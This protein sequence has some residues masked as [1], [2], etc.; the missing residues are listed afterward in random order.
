MYS[1]DHDYNMVA[2]VLDMHRQLAGLLVVKRGVIDAKDLEIDRLVCQ[3]Y[4]L[5]ER[6]LS[7]IMLFAA[8]LRSIGRAKCKNTFAFQSSSQH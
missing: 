6:E 3:L 7:D 4:E 1:A 5:S 2:K 8:R